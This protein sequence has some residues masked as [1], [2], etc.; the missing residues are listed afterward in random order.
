MAKISGF[1]LS[2]GSPR[3]EASSGATT[4]TFSNGLEEG[5]ISCCVSTFVQYSD[6]MV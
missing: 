3:E 6:G 1:Q 5:V 4:N 2:Y